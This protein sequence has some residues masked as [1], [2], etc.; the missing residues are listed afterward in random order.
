VWTVDHGQ[1][2]L[3]RADLLDLAT[4]DHDLRRRQQF[5]ECAEHRDRR[6]RVPLQHFPRRT[7]GAIRGSEIAG[8]TEEISHALE[9]ERGD[10]VPEGMASSPYALMRWKSVS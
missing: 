4:K 2:L 9:N 3:R 10:A 7:H 6:R 8:L 1:L 5:L